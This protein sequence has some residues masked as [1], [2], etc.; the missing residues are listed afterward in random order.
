MEFLSRPRCGVPDCRQ[1]GV[2]LLRLSLNGAEGVT[3]WFDEN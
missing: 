3:P 1:T 2:K